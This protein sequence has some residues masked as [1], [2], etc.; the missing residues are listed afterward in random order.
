MK[1]RSLAVIVICLGAAW[2]VACEQNQRP[3][4]TGAQQTETAAPETEQPQ[5]QAPPAVPATEQPKTEAPAVAPAEP[6]DLT[7]VN[8][9]PKGTKAGTGFNVQ[10]DGA[11][12]IFF[13][14]K[15]AGPGLVIM[16]NNQDLPKPAISRATN[17]ISASVPD[18]LIQTAGEFEVFVMD[19]ES[20]RKSEPVMFKVE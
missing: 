4:Q 17:T 20:G 9:G 3:A 10:A 5:Q 16:F 1:L 15:H 12:A 7:I 2:L 11:S 19:K 8:W 6:V 14:V 13:T 18:E